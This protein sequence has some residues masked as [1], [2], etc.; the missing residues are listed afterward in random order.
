MAISAIV[1]AAAFHGWRRQIGAI[2]QN[3][4]VL[5]QLGLLACFLLLAV[6]EFSNESWHG[7]ALVEHHLS[8]WQLTLALAG[9]LSRSAAT[10]NAI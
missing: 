1:V 2:V 7:D 8:A 4:V 3:S 10:E 5:F 6:S 9:S